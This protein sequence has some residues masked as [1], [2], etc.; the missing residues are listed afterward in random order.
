MKTSLQW[1]RTYLPEAPDA[2]ACGDKLT[3]AGLPTE[4]FETYESDDVFDVEVT[5][6]RSDCLSHVGLARELGALL[7]LTVN[8]PPT[9][10]PPGAVK[11]GK[12]VPVRIDDAAGCPLYTARV[13]RGVKVGPSP[14]WMQRH[15][16]SVGLRPINNVVD[17]TNFVLLEMG[18][19]LHAFDLG[20]LAGPEIVVRRA[21]ENEELV[22]LDGHTRKLEPWM[23]VIADR[24]KPAALAGIM[25]G[26]ES[27]VADATT[28][29]L[30]E[31]AIF[32][33]LTI[34]KTSRKLGLRSD[35]SYRFER[36]ID[37]TLPRRAS[38]RAARL[39][40]EL[41]GGTLVEGESA[42]GR[43]EPAPRRLTL[44]F[45]KLKR[46]LGYD[47][48][49]EA[50]VDALARLRMTPTL[51][52][53]AGLVRVVVPP[54]RLDVN[55]EVDLVEEVARVTG[56]EHIPQKEAIEVRLTP[57]D[58]A[59]RSVEI[60]NEV[61]VGSGYFEAIT[62]SFVT[63][64]LATDFMPEGAV[65]L[66]RAD[67]GTRKADAQLRPSLVPGLLEAVRRNEA[68]GNGAVKLYESGSTFHVD[69]AGKLAE[70]RRVAIVG[71]EDVQRTRGV[72]E[73]L[74]GRLDARLPVRV[75]PAKVNG[76]DSGGVIY[77]GEQTVGV[78][79]VVAQSV[80]TKLDLRHT[81][82]AA[83]LELSPLLD[84]TRHVPQL[85]PLPRYPAVER[86]VSLVVKE[87][88]K[89]DTIQSL[90][91]GLKLADLERATHVTTY[92]GKP[93]DKGVK[94]VTVR[95]VFR[96]GERSLKAEEVDGAVNAF[97]DK[98][99]ADVGAVLRV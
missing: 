59:A 17:V 37:P 73:A 29:I 95:L 52:S 31:S 79:G 28:D 7:G 3:L 78:L 66:P 48:T 81:P 8:E 33:P 99:K 94:S 82:C 46:V 27:E 22:S 83:E 74:L 70:T 6:N 15:L 89:Y 55:I 43:P 54:D 32:E 4:T 93:L 39:I 63:D 61:L 97:V 19:P 68:S 13:I 30:L 1:L 44:R 87:D 84:N 60:V 14:A 77:W 41:A 90:L 76:Y 65:S 67:H 25:G 20:K 42:A 88:V 23:L 86:D 38:L 47:I 5:S 9:A 10:P 80:V 40:L 24:D 16:L 96:S 72:V 50:A 49:P 26:K 64:A 91:A 92:R 57:P 51:D 11:P 53:A 36:G 71:G 69:T 98:A 56:Y 12:L 34:R 75:E 2:Q 35:S 18:Q 45:E 62:F 58:L 21:R 85:V